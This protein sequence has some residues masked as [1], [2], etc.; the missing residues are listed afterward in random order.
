MDSFLFSASAVFPIIALV[1]LGYLLKRMG[2][3]S[4]SFAREANKLVFHVFLP[5]MLFVNVSKITSPENMELSYILYTVAAVIA[6]FFI[7]LPLVMAVTKDP[8][9]R[10]V[11]LQCSFRSNFSY[12]GIPLAL[13]L[14]GDEGV[15]TASLLSAALIPVFNILAV[16]ALSVF[17]RDG[18]KPDAK[19]ILLNILKN[20]LIRAVFL[21]IIY[22]VI[23]ELLAS[24]GVFFDLLSV[25]MIAKP[26]N[27]LGNVATPLALIALGAQFEFSAAGEMKKEILFGTL[28]RVFLVP[29]AAIFIAVFS[30][31]FEGQHF[32]AFMGAFATPVAIS[33]VPMAQEMGADTSLAGQ[34]V[35]W[36]TL[37]SAV[38]VFLFIFT[39]SAIGIF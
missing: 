14:F 29:A 27:Y 30:H 7:S 25:E 22:L 17:R 21:G 10:G 37:L 12:I 31:A 38:T 3:I 20:P 8:S 34:L 1:V 26:L 33:S 4:L 19:S 5:V 24:R 16:V 9:R 18:K 11:L 6:V 23:R 15:A 39:L 35:I 28:M 13:S 36:T 2:F 32:A